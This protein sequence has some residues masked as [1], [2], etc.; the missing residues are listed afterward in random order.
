MKIEFDK[1]LEMGKKHN[2][3]KQDM[4]NSI[5]LIKSTVESLTNRMDHTK[6]KQGLK[7]KYRRWIT[8][9]KKTIHSFKK[10]MELV[11]GSVGRSTCNQDWESE[12]DS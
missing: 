11:N 6:D 8:H 2:E 7:K 5:S 12:F 10:Y 9:S 3:V 4:K 1:E